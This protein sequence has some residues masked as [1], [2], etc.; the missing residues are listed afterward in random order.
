MS[1]AAAGKTVVITMIVSVNSR[2]GSERA[3][4]EFARSTC[5]PPERT[6]P[7]AAGQPNLEGPDHRHKDEHKNAEHLR[8]D[9]IGGKF[10]VSMPTM[11]VVS[12]STWAGVPMMTAVENVPKPLIQPEGLP[13]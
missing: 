2:A 12:K 8:A 3:Q 4:R 7:A 13:I 5:A 9:Q 6:E 10:F 1:R 11:R